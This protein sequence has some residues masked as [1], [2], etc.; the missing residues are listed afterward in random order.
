[1]SPSRLNPEV[2]AFLGRAAR[3]PDEM[4]CLRSICLDCELTEAFKWGKPGYTLDGKNVVLIQGFKAYCA[5]LFF[6]G[7]L[8]SD[9]AGILKRMGA[10]THVG[11]QLRFTHRREII[12][13]AA[14]I[15]AYIREAIA[16]EKAG[17]Q[18]APKPNSELKIPEELTVKFAASPAFK[19]A[20]A[21]LT[22]GRQR[23]YVY[24]FSAAK[25][26]PTRTARIEKH[27]Q[28]ILEG[29]GLNER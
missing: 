20:F 15:K 25:Q 13:Q 16:V 23:A 7:A 8:L 12:A 4:Q 3:W 28:A 5:L 11:R 17:L 18:V 22:P 14:L 6:K 10:N 9:P 21:A 26:S 29:K 2:D 19:T 27:Q 24:Y 1:M